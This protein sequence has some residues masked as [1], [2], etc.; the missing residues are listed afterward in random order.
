MSNSGHEC[1]PSSNRL[2]ICK[3]RARHREEPRATKAT[4]AGGNGGCCQQTRTLTEVVHAK[5]PPRPSP[6]PQRA[7]RGGGGGE[8]AHKICK[9]VATETLRRSLVK[10]SW[11]RSDISAHSLVPKPRRFSSQNTPPPCPA[12][13]P[14][15]SFSTRRVWSVRQFSNT[16]PSPPT[17]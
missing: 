5:T 8:Q 1:L 12:Q 14:N 15:T 3:K 11:K 16:P 7:V 4:R 9:N 6:K 2:R 10:R 13:P 17:A